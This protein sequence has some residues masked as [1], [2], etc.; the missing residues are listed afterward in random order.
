MSQVIGDHRLVQVGL[1]RFIPS[2]AQPVVSQ[3]TL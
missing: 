2:F 3:V 1:E